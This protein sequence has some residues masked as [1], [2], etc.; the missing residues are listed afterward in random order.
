IMVKP[1]ASPEADET[2]LCRSFDV[3]VALVIPSDGGAKPVVQHRQQRFHAVRVRL[4]R[5][6]DGQRSKRII[7]ELNLQGGVAHHLIDNVAERLILEVETA[8]SPAQ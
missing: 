6:S 7:V 8:L 2:L 4:K 5:A 1:R 3:D